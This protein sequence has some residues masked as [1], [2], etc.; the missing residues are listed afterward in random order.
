MFF[1]DENAVPIPHPVR[2][3]DVCFWI[4]FNPQVQ[5][6]EWCAEIHQ[7]VLS[8]FPPQIKSVPGKFPLKRYFVNVISLDELGTVNVPPPPADSGVGSLEFPRSCGLARTATGVAGPVCV[9]PGA[10][11][12]NLSDLHDDRVGSR[13]P[14]PTHPLLNR[15]RLPGIHQTSRWTF[16]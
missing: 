14:G 16:F 7:F 6:S 3:W 8:Y 12:L 2:D 11:P 4:L 13:K 15:A 10:L 9:A 5:L 1:F